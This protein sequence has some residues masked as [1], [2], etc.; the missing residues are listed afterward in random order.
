MSKTGASDSS[1]S[2]A[3]SR[4]K[5]DSSERP[6]IVAAY[7][8][9]EPFR[10]RRVKVPPNIRWK[11]F[12]A[13][14][15]SRL[16]I[17][18]NSNIEIY[19][20]Q[21]IEIVDVDDL[22]ENDVLVVRDMPPSM[23]SS[24]K[25]SGRGQPTNVLGAWPGAGMGRTDGGELVQRHPEQSSNTAAAVMKSHDKSHDLGEHSMMVSTPQL[26][27]FIQLNSFGYYF[28]AEV[29]NMKLVP[30]HGKIKK[31]HC[32]VKVPHCQKGIQL[33]AHTQTHTHTH[34]TKH[35]LQRFAGARVL[36]GNHNLHV[37]E[38]LDYS[39]VWCCGQ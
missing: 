16:E 18:Q 27:H 5:I 33:L 1:S 39:A 7:R 30:T 19:D 17:D 28:L 2:I 24:S 9:G 25:S 11:D 32:I 8:F 3:G 36:I 34:Q 26:S 6:L 15:Y 13:L 29:E 31:I 4:A 21:G 23:K 10:K 20:E 14:V 22:V 38:F 37:I 35:M 12:L